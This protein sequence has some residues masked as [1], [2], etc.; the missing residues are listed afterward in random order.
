MAKRFRRPA[1]ALIVVV[2]AL[3]GLVFSPGTLAQSGQQPAAADDSPQPGPAPRRDLSGTWTPASGPGG[4]IQARGV[5]A[6]PNDGRPE[7]AL[8]YTPYG[9]ELYESHRP[10]EGVDAVLPAFH[11][12]PRNM[13]EPLGMP[14]VNHYNVRMTQIF[15]NPYKVAI[16]Y[17]YDNKWRNIWIDGR[18][19]PE[20]A[21]GGVIAGGTYK[22]SK[23]YGYSVGEWI[24]DYTLVVRTAGMMPEDRVW[25]DST[26]RPI[27]DAVTV[28]EVFHRVDSDH[29]EWTETIDDPKVYTEPWVTMKILFRLADPHT[30]IIEMY[31]SPVE[32]KYYYDSF[33]NAASGVENDEN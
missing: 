1:T 33:G 3:T 4:G 10:L 32:M 7:H 5:Q 18:D 25:L 22:A 11:N 19:L 6:A 14:R 9:R 20:P 2:A 21:D 26:G 24:D 17:Q 29:M 13:C 30:D 15:Q 12:D 31:C 28:E 23:W 16:L 8:P 27:S